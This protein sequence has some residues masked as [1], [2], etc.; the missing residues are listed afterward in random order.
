MVTSFLRSG[1][2]WLY[3]RPPIIAGSLTM[4][5][6]WWVWTRHLCAHSR[7]AH[8]HVPALSTH[9]SLFYL[10]CGMGKQWVWDGETGGVWDKETVGVF[11][12]G[13]NLLG[14]VSKKFKIC[15]IIFIELNGWLLKP[16]MRHS[17]QSWKKSLRTFDGDC[18]GEELQYFVKTKT[19]ILQSEG[20]LCRSSNVAHFFF[21]SFLFS[22]S[23]NLSVR[24]NGRNWGWICKGICKGLL[25]ID[26]FAGR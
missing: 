8:T 5:E 4:Q 25:W 19:C 13:Y 9:T 17:I 26:T 14:L 12:F 2:W 23:D 15:L 16:R 18:R 1:S 7:Y 3:S 21:L 20:H 24:M 11:F 22:S 10:V 6:L